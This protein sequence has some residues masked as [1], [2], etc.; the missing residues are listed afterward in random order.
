MSHSIFENGGIGIDLNDD[1]VTPNDSTDSDEGPNRLQNK[2]Q[3]AWLPGPWV[4]AVVPGAV[5]GMTYRIEVFVNSDDDP[6]AR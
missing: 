2:A 6:R 1:G 3:L 5:V 4:E